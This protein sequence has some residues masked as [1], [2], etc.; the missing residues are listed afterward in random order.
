M[1]NVSYLC[2][3]VPCFIS[4]FKSGAATGGE[5]FA[6]CGAWAL[7]DGVFCSVLDGA[8]CSILN[9]DI[10]DI[11]GVIIVGVVKPIVGGTI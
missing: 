5:V 3:L 2:P 11:G 9:W 8:F 4:P 7:F 6:V 1:S 10:P